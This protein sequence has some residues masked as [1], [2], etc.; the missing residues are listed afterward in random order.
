MDLYTR[1]G[2]DYRRTRKTDPYIASCIE[3][4]LLD[5]VTVLNVGAGTGSYESPQ[6]RV[7]AL[8][9]SKVMIRHRDKA[10]A[11]AVLGRAEAIPFADQS[12]DAVT[13]FLT[14]QHWTEVPRGLCELRRVARRRVVITTYLP[15]QPQ[16]EERWLTGIYFPGIC[17]AHKY[18]FPPLRAYEQ[19]L[20]PVRC[21]PLLIP[22]DCVD[23]FLD[24]YWAR[25]EV[26]LDAGARAAMSGFQLLPAAELAQGLERLRADL[27]QGIWD[28]R[29]GYLRTC[30]QA[31]LSP[32][33]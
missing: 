6:R 31:A 14:V 12:F 15:E 33:G 29:F 21:T 7:I 24:A 2:K 30:D 22:R 26:Y 8:D 19:A 5:C 16:S 20:G 27:A 10:T 13:A 18:R 1:I 3:D 23:G 11:P 4:A 17:A 9:P 28:A 25:P 32:S